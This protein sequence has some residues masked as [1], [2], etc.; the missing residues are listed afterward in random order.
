MVVSQHL[1]TTMCPLRFAQVCRPHSGKV[2]ERNRLIASVDNSLCLSDM[3]GDALVK[4][5]A[6][7][8]LQPSVLRLGFFQDGDVGIDVFPEG[9]EVFVGNSDLADT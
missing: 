5:S 8:A 6:I 7:A 9:E 2:N 3:N 4:R 1:R